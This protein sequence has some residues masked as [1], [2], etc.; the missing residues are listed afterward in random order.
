MKIG[1]SEENAVYIGKSSWEG[2]PGGVASASASADTVIAGTHGPVAKPA[3]AG[4]RIPL[5]TGGPR[6]CLLDHAPAI[7]YLIPDAGRGNGNGKAGA[8]FPTGAAVTVNANGVLVRL[9][10]APSKRLAFFR[11]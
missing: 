3:P 1:D 6:L 8:A 5:G 10:G 7:Y 9:R 2:D 4:Y 11:R